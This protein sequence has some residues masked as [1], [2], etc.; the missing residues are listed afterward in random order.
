MSTYLGFNAQDYGSS[1]KD[2]ASVRELTYAFRDNLP[3]PLNNTMIVMSRV[4]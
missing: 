1:L 4:P 2:S 3:T